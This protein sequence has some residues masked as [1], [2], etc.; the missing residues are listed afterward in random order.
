[1]RF[2]NETLRL[3]VLDRVAWQPSAEDAAP[4]DTGSR[5]AKWP[6][7]PYVHDSSERKIDY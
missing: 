1:M 5:D 6:Y 2:T 3:D 7:R 4:I